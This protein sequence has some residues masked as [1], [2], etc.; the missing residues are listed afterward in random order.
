MTPILKGAY[1]EEALEHLAPAAPPLRPGD[2]ET[3]AAP[4]D[5]L[6]VNNYSCRLVRAATGGPVD[7]RSPS[8]PLTA[9]GW[10]VYPQGLYEVLTRV[11]R[12][13][14]PPLVY[15]TENGAAYADVR[16]HDGRVHDPERVSY[17][18]GYL[19]AMTR[20]LCEGVPVG[21]YFVWSLLDNFEWA[22]GYAKRFGLVFVDYPTQERVPKDSFGWYRETI[23]RTRGRGAAATP[24]IGTPRA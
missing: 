3:I 20:A 16:T 6:G 1:P 14:A 4:I 13:Y 21:G 7:V 24:L 18:D 12:E 23:A 8:G 15:V 17:L 19:R 11:Q 9:T 22:E 10:E 5:F 2:L